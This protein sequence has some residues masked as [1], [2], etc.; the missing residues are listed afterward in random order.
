MLGCIL[1]QDQHP[2][3][4]AGWT[5]GSGDRTPGSQSWFRARNRSRSIL[6]RSRGWATGTLWVGQ[7]SRHHRW[8]PWETTLY[9]DCI[10]MPQNGCSEVNY[11]INI[12][13]IIFFPQQ[14]CGLS[15]ITI[16][17]API[18]IV[19]SPWA[20]TQTFALSSCPGNSCVASGT[21][22][23]MGDIICLF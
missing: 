7:E 8:R 23:P 13:T 2:K 14:I 20:D 15:F 1:L 22:A 18:M 12:N 4:T 16:R 3:W 11:I 10:S 19:L 9:Q 6:W 5:V 17:T 21:P